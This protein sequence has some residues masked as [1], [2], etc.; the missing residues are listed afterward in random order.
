MLSAGPTLK[1]TCFRRDASKGQS[2]PG[3]KASSPAKGKGTM[4]KLQLQ[5]PP[6]SSPEEEARAGGGP[7]TEML[8]LLL[9]LFV[10]GQ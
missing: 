2:C 10:G 9:I 7:R 6:R 3:T 4:V 8:V 5:A 1:L